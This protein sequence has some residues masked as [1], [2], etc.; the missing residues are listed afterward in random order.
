MSR[1]I[2]NSIP[3]QVKNETSRIT[4]KEWNYIINVLKNQTNS[5]SKLISDLDKKIIDS[6]GEGSLNKTLVEK[7]ENLNINGKF[8][9]PDGSINLSAKDLL[10]DLEET[11]KDIIDELILEK[12][13]ASDVMWGV[14]AV[15]TQEEPLAGL[16]IIDNYQLKAEDKVLVTGLGQ[17]KNGVYFAQSGNWT[18]LEKVKT[19]QVINVKYGDVYGGSLLKKLPIGITKVVKEPERLFWERI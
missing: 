9:K 17:E 12:D 11:L 3:D 10:S 14:V 6:L 16:R 18:F 4:P 7:I 15:H 13:E 19:Y 5:N 1:I 8:F 2:Y